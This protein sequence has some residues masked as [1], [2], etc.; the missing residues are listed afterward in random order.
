[1][2]GGWSG[3]AAVLLSMA[4]APLLAGV[5]GK[6]KALVAG[7]KGA[8]LLQLYRDLARLAGKGAAYSSA[9]TWIFKAGPSLSLAALLMAAL[10]VPAGPFRPPLSFAGDVILFAYL[11]AL[12]RFAILAAAMDTGSSFEGMGAS[13]EAAFS[14]LAEPALFLVVGALAWNRGVLHLAGIFTA[15]PEGPS[16]GARPSWRCPPVRSSC[17]CWRR[18]A[19]FPWTTRRPT[20]NSP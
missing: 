11:L 5:I 8:P 12:S 2:S 6:T 9:T 13:R 15:A 19:G 16:G 14:A 1:M 7:R 20:S 10:I 4:L 17:C 3:A 18:T